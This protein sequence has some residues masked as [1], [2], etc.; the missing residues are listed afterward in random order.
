MKIPAKAF[1]P[2]ALAALTAGGA[3]ASSV[4]VFASSSQLSASDATLVYPGTAP[5]SYTSPVTYS[6]GGNS[7]TFSDAG[8]KFE[9]DEAGV[10]YDVTSFPGGTKI[11]FA[12]GFAGAAG[13][14]TLNFAHPITQFG[15]NAEEYAAGP[16]TIAVRAYDGSTFLGGTRSIGCDPLGDCVNYYGRLSFEGIESKNGLPITSIVISDNNGDNIGL[17]PITFGGTPSTRTPEPSSLLLLTSALGG[18]ALLT[19]FR[20]AI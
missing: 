11:F 14:I 13:P 19:A 8:G 2:I 15:F 3:R 4:F 17:G 6:V 5:A 7:L 16:Y 1:L 9:L 18:L 10:T 20:K 12:S